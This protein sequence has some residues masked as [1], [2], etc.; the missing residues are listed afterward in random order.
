MSRTYN[1]RLVTR[2]GLSGIARR[3]WVLL[4]ASMLVSTALVVAFVVLRRHQPL[5]GDAPEYDLEGRFIAQGHWFWT[6]TPYGIAH[7][8]A[9][10][11]P[12]YPAWVGVA[13]AI[14]GDHAVRV[15]L[16][17]ALLTPATVGLTWWLARR[18]FGLPA[19]LAAAWIVALWPLVWQWNG[20]LYS[21]ALAVPLGLLILALGIVSPP[22]PRRAAGI[23][24]LL[25]ITLLLRPSSVFL[26]AGLAA[27]W[28]AVAG[29][30]R[31]ALMTGVTIVLAALVVAPWTIR[32]AHV[33]GG[34]VPI[35][36]QDAAAYGT[37][38]DDAAHDPI[39]P[40]A[41]RPAPSDVRPVFS[42]PRSDITFYHDLQRLA[43][44]YINA[45]PV[46]VLKAFFWNGLSRLWDVRRPARALVE[47]RFEGRSHD[48][49]A[50]GL[51]MYYVL[52]VGAL[53]GLWRWRRRRQILWASIA[54]T[55]AA[56]IVFTSDSGTRYRAPLQPLVAIL[57]CG[58]IPRLTRSAPAPPTGLSEL[59]EGAVEGSAR[60]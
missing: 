9:W 58:A 25:G 24:V 40:Y 13:Y 14:L 26:I 45:H 60:A 6:T 29:L 51:G 34:F 17:Q 10:K 5:A 52:L 4:A 27:A 53:A 35:S 33:L 3:E 54:L 39:Y 59:R 36:I 23:G 15:E 37:F 42:H 46:S 7:A 44:D 55:L 43:V 56:G 8:S 16:L 2:L 47:T 19:A 21:E 50:I 11:A 20:L 22:S 38:N 1:A 28:I 30:R 49:T 57:A 48:L 12:A 31:G 18:L 32:N 41:W